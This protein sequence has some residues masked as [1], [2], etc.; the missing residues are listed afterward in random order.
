LSGI[1]GISAGLHVYYRALIVSFFPERSVLDKK[2]N[3]GGKALR[4]S[5]TNGTVSKSSKSFKGKST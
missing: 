3:N 4:E 2:E 1:L 5:S